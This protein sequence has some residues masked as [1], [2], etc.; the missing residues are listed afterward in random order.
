MTK[1]MDQRRRMADCCE[2]TN[3]RQEEVIPKPD[4][5][6]TEDMKIEELGMVELVVENTVVIKGKTSE[7]IE[8]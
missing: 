2:T 8:C 7:N 4:I 1:E 3:E 5:V 6:V